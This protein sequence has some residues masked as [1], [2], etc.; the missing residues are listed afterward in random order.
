MKLDAWRGSIP[1][2]MKRLSEAISTWSIITKIRP[3]CLKPCLR[4]K[5][6]FCVCRSI[7]TKLSNG[8]IEIHAHLVFEDS[9]KIQMFVDAPQNLN[10]FTVGEPRRICVW[11]VDL[12]PFPLLSLKIRGTF[13]SRAANS[14]PPAARL[15]LWRSK[16]SGDD[17]FGKFH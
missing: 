3:W 1:I 16:R 17:D 7:L 2:Q 13:H 10:N 4:R 5:S 14:L 11:K 9:W 8:K 15:N 6:I 12:D